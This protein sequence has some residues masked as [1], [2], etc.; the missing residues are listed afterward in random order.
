VGSAQLSLLRPPILLAGAAALGSF[1]LATASPAAAGGLGPDPAP[2]TVV[3]PDA[4]PTPRAP[5]VVVTPAPTPTV[6]KVV[7][8]RPPPP[9]RP[10]KAAPATHH[11]ATPKRQRPLPFP[12]L[13][14]KW[15][16]GA[17]VPAAARSREVPARVALVLAALVLA[18]AA[19]V[20][21][22]A[23]EAAR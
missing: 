20:A 12:T 19:L 18:S 10:R 9:A 15:F 6:T 23:R 17:A 5:E 13:A 22:A 11:G 16:S 7:A 2:A 8:V 3:R 1:L 4:Y 21:G 14:I